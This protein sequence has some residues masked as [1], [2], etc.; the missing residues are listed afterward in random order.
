MEWS[1]EVDHNPITELPKEMGLL[2]KLWY[3]PLQGLT[4]NFPPS[5]I[6]T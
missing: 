4:L 3:L 5:N 2:D 1:L 6:L